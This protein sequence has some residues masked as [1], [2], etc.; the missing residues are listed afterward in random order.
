MP[1]RTAFTLIELLVVISI[2]ALLIGLLLPALGSAREMARRS[3]CTSNLHQIAV[4]A[5]AFAVDHKGTLP[6]PFGYGDPNNTYRD[7]RRDIPAPKRTYAGSTS[8]SK[9]RQLSAETDPVKYSFAQMFVEGYIPVPEGFY[10]PGSAEP[11]A[12]P[13]TDLFMKGGDSNDPVRGFRA[14]YMWNPHRV[15]DVNSLEAKGGR[16]AGEPSYLTV[17]DMP[18]DKVLVIDVLENL[19]NVNAGQWQAPHGES[20]QSAWGGAFIDGSAAFSDES[21]FNQM[22]DMGGTGGHWGRFDR[23]RHTFEQSTR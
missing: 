10:C 13:G 8:L 2:I 21:V 5:T 20:T 1:R 23:V 14:G 6:L 7:G 12:F 18:N 4:G 3:V 11:Y 19:Y 9:T 16:E 15:G 22:D 17:D